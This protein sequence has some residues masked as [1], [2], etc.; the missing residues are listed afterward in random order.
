M[1]NEK[2]DIGGG[3]ERTIASGL[4]KFIPLEDMKDK[5][6]IVL[7][8]LRP[9]KLAEWNS[10]GMVMCAETENKSVV[11]LLIPPAGSKP[12]DLIS[13]EGFPR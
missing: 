9:R 4:Q 7:V 3:E 12:G 5:L 13:F 6:C 2:V 11:E 8:N 10:H 1:Y